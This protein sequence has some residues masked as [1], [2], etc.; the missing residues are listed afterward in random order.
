MYA[1]RCTYMH[2]HKVGTKG[3]RQIVRKKN[4][5]KRKEEEGR[6]WEVHTVGESGL[7][8]CPEEQWTALLHGSAWCAAPSVHRGSEQ[9]SCPWWHPQPS[10]SSCHQAQSHGQQRRTEH[11][12]SCPAVMQNSPQPTAKCI[13]GCGLESSRRPIQ[14]EW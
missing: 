6:E 3:W 12:R 8:T 1:I 14:R 9:G 11:R 4:V 5:R 7:G 13:V 2:M 10:C